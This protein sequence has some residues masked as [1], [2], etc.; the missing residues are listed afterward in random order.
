TS[1]HQ[2]FLA[3]VDRVAGVAALWNPA[4]VIRANTDKR[5]LTR[6][7]AAG[8]PVVPTE[9]I[10][11]G[12]SRQL[13]EILRERGWPVAVV[14]PAVSVAAY[15]TMRFTADHADAAQALAD[16][17]ALGRDV[18]VQPYLH[19]VEAY[20][21]RS[22]IHFGG[23]FSHAVRKAPML[24]GATS[25]DDVEA[26]EATDAEIALAQRALSWVATDLMYARIDVAQLD[27]GT[28]VIME[29]ELTEPRLFLRYADAADRFAAVIAE[30]A[31]ASS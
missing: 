19:S 31:R 21:E 25:P 28:P 14:K 2:E 12:T 8:V 9:W 24:A 11:R 30:A 29:L 10:D 7:E 26:A 20:G 18:M 16:E 27:D 15:D 4:P 17:I 13:D 5:Y 3:W 22:L 23:S 1:R 6:L